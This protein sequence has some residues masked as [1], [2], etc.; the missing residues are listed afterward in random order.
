MIM[1]D[2]IIMAGTICIITI[3]QLQGAY[4]NNSVMN[5]DKGKEIAPLF[6]L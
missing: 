6:L 2:N 5:I 1:T 3:T 4:G